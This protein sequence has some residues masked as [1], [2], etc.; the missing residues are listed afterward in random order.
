MTRRNRALPLSELAALAARA[1]RLAGFDDLA[2]AAALD[3]GGDSSG[4]R[5]PRS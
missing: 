2:Q 1:P 5:D 4:T 3:D